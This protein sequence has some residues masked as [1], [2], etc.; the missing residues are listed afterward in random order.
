QRKFRLDVASPG[1]RVIRLVVGFSCCGSYNLVVFLNKL[2]HVLKLWHQGLRARYANEMVR[3]EITKVL[4]VTHAQ[5][6]KDTPMNLWPLMKQK[7][8]QEI[9]AVMDGKMDKPDIIDR[10]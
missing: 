9:Q 4:Q 10:R 3:R 5:E 7:Q 2:W 8:A 6:L 1:H